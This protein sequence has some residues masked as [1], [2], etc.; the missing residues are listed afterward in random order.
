MTDKKIGR[1]PTMKASFTRRAAL[2]ATAGLASIALIGRA[3]AQR[4]PEAS[5]VMTMANA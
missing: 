3:K 5:R 1:E 4:A 2:G